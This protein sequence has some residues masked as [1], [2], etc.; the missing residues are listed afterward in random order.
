MEATKDNRTGRALAGWVAVVSCP[1]AWLNIY[2]FLTAGSFDTHAMF[3]PTFA[4]SLGAEQ[5]RFFAWSML[6]D[7]F[8]FY[9]SFLVVGGYLWSRLRPSAVADMAV[10]CLVVYV[11]LGIAG[12][13]MQYATLPV[14]TDVYKSGDA[15]AKAGAATA[16]L[17]L[18]NATQNGL[19]WMEGPVMAFWAIATGTALKSA[20][21]RYGPLLVLAGVAYGA[22]FILVVVGQ[23]A[24]AEL[25]EFAGL[26]LLPLWMLLTGITLLR[27]R[28]PAEAMESAA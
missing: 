21:L 11:L 25:I 13:A 19:W 4:L 18:V 3:N 27:E 17:A 28:E 10:L 24:I 12:T 15:A 6:A 26:L 8:G 2:F 1:I 5:Q 14:L 9:L 20:G 16:W 23:G 7:S 22:Y